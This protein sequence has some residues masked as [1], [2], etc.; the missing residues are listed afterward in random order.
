MKK[1]Y[2]KMMAKC[3]I[4]KASQPHSCLT[5]VAWS[6]DCVNASST[7]W[8]FI[9]EVFTSANR[10]EELKMVNVFLNRDSRVEL[11]SFRDEQRPDLE[12]ILFEPNEYAQ[13]SEGFD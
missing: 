5:H 9:Q 2:C 7:A 3:L 1:E 6:F 4:D 12:L 10:M 11:R 13:D 8:N